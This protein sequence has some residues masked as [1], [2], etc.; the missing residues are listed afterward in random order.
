LRIHF[1]INRGVG[2]VAAHEDKAWLQRTVR[3]IV[4]E[5]LDK[6]VGDIVRRYN[7]DGTW[8]P[9][10]DPNPMMTVASG[11]QYT[12]RDANQAFLNV[13]DVVIPALERIEEKLPDTGPA[14]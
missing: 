8:V 12:G 1:E 6:R 9:M 2:A 7:P 5:E 13:R 14:E 11:V 4:V 10:T 3:S